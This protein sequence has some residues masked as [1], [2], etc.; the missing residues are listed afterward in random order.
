M[1]I[2]CSN[3]G[4]FGVLNYEKELMDVIKDSEFYK[5]FSMRIK[6]LFTH[7]RLE[8]AINV[9]AVWLYD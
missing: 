4:S 6:S 5:A 7:K 2:E 1:I 9:K 8:K 3:V